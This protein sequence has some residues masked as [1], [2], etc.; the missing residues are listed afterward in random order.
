MLLFVQ[1]NFCICLI[2]SPCPQVLNDE[3]KRKTYDAHG[4]EGLK[5]SGGGGDPFDPFSRLE[6][7]KHTGRA[8]GQMVWKHTGK[9][10]GQMVWKHTGKSLG[11]MVW[12][13]T[14][15]S[16]GQMVW[17]HTGKSLGQMVWKHTGKSLGQMVW[18]HTGKSLGQMVWKHTGKSLGQMV[19]KQQAFNSSWAEGWVLW[20]KEDPSLQSILVLIWLLPQ[21]IVP[22]MPSS[23]W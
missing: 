10:L 5:N 1:G 9:S 14:G 7:W 15:K 22:T 17:K 11:Q 16:L 4:E 19:W 18:K 3:E 2:W 13:H 23:I 20:V 21:I 6:T 12:K 8:L